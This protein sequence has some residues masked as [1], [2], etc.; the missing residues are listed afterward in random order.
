V[1]GLFITFE[2]PEGAGKSTQIQRLAEALIRRN[3]R[4]CQTREPGGTLLGERIRGLLLD[5]GT[6]TICA[7]A[8]A[9]LHTAARAQHVHELIRPALERGKIVLCDRFLD[10]TLAYQ[11]GGRQLPIDELQ[12]LQ[13]LATA[14]IEPTMKFLLDLAVE[15]GLRR[16]IQGAGGSNRMDNED[17]AF[18]R[19]VRACYLSMA[20]ANPEAWRV[21]EATLPEEV[22][23]RQVLA[24]V[25]PLLGQFERS[26]V[27]GTM[28]QI[29]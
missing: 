23:A 14:G 5:E 2:G 20:E 25:E 13:R 26:S 21:I 12:N 8:E 9:Y 29:R 16:R 6:H 10:S 4:V 22:V 17:V 11:G 27:A 1:A 24:E 7:E 3:F 19:R 28:E 15:T 18:H